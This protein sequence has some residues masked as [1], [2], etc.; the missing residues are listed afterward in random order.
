MAIEQPAISVKKIQVLQLAFVILFSL[1]SALF[2]SLE[3]AG[4]VLVGG[5]LSF[6]SFFWLQRDIQNIFLGPLRA[7]KIL[8]FV[9]YYARLALLAVVLYMVVKNRIFNVIGLLVGLSTVMLSI[10][11]TGIGEVRKMHVNVKEAA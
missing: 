9:K 5:L 6:L 3:I 11:I 4:A 7:A 8:F 10:V 1:A 2:Y